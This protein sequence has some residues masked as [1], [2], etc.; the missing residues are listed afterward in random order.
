MSNLIEG[1]APILE[2]LRLLYL[3]WI[4]IFFSFQIFYNWPSVSFYDLYCFRNGQIGMS[5]I[6]QSQT[7]IPNQLSRYWYL[8]DMDSMVFCYQQYSW[9]WWTH[10]PPN[11]SATS[12]THNHHHLTICYRNSTAWRLLLSVQSSIDSFTVS[13]H[14]PNGRHLPAVRAVQGDC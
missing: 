13:L 4:N 9:H 10:M 8:F 14:S 1:T 5:P 3:I 2:R 11:Y 12:A 6:H 7:L